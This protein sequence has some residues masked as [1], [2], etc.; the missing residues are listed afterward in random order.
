MFCEQ[1]PHL[2]PINFYNTRSLIRSLARSPHPP[3]A[4]P[5]PSAPNLK[6]LP[7]LPSPRPRVIIKRG[8]V[9]EWFKA[10]VLK[11]GRLTPR[12]FESCP[13]RHAYGRK[14]LQISNTSMPL[15]NETTNRHTRMQP[16]NLIG[17]CWNSKVVEPCPTA[18]A[19]PV[20]GS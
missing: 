19:R 7:N 2:S 20:I 13:F 15:P 17:C 5:A 14:T 6:P 3:F 4:R 11:T 8:R 10:P 12:K 9:A 18:A 1:F 16:N